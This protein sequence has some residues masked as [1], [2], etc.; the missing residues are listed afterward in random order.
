MVLKIVSISKSSLRGNML[1]KVFEDNSDLEFRE[2]AFNKY[3]IWYNSN[4]NRGSE[5]INGV[6]YLNRVKVFADANKDNWKD[7]NKFINEISNVNL[8]K[9]GSE[10]DSETIEEIVNRYEHLLP[11][12]HWVRKMAYLMSAMFHAEDNWPDTILGRSMYV[13]ETLRVGV[14]GE[15]VQHVCDTYTN[16]TLNEIQRLIGE[17]YNLIEVKLGRQSVIDDFF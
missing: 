10:V 11:N 1:I 6:S 3:L 12:K 16:K 7:I 2:G 17:T 14:L 8:I 15:D 13:S 5:C 9:Y 4:S